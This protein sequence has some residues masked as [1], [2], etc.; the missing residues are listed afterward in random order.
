MGLTRTG[1]V[2]GLARA[3]W[4]GTG[5]LAVVILIVVAMSPGACGGRARTTVKLMYAGS[6]IIPFD[7]LAAEF[8]KLHPEYRVFTE[9]HGSIQVIRHVTEMDDPQDLI[10]TADAQLIPPMMYDRKTAAGKP[11]ADW[12]VSFATNRMVLVYTAKSHFGT[13][14]T[15][16]NWYKVIARPGVRFGLADPRF[17]ANGYRSLMVLQLAESYYHDP[18]IFEN[19][20]LA[21]FNPSITVAQHGA[22]SVIHVPELLEP[23]P[24]GNVTVRDSSVELL[25]L[26]QSGDVDYAFEYE[27]VA[28]QHGLKYLRLPAALDLGTEKDVPFYRRVSVHLDF[29]RFASVKPEF[30]GGLISYALTIPSTAAQPKAAA[31]FAAFVLGPEGRRILKQEYQPLIEPPVAD[32]YRRLPK[33]LRKLCVAGKAGAGSGH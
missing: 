10:V 3:R 23:Q 5:L 22:R 12:Y 27:S 31:Q 8:Q 17:D 24:N 14:L 13:N 19:L 20:M 7:R 33:L 16:R 29:H 11:W 18:I 32:G 15:A 4:A 30:Q 26:L 6:L 25:A 28:R 2:A 21:A 9:S 1:L